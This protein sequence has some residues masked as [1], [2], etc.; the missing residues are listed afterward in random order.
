MEPYLS[1]MPKV[2]VDLTPEL[3]DRLMKYV[4]RCRGTLYV[5][6]SDVIA[7]AVKEFLDH[8]ERRVRRANG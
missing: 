1:I 6:R 8:H 5:Q 4:V 3:N 7:E 2:E